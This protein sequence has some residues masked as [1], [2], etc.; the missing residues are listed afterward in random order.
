MKK[1]ALLLVAAALALSAASVGA[2]NLAGFDASKFP[3][4]VETEGVWRTVNTTSFKDGAQFAPS[5]AQLK[6]IMKLTSLSP[7]SVGMT[8]YLLVV[9]KDAAQQEDVIGKGKVNSG[10]V[11][12]LVFGDR[13]IATEQSLG[14]HTQQLDRGYYNAGIVSGYL[15]L[16]ALS[17]GFG[18]HF[19]MT[20]EYAAA[21]K[22]TMSLED[23]Y[24]KGKGYKYGIGYDPYK[25]GDANKQAEAYG[26]LKFI[27]G[28][29]IGTLDEKAQTKVTDHG[30]PENW[31]VAK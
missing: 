3:A 27:C 26:N 11:T 10:T 21:G 13:L 23:A 15:N 12:V 5:E 31:V 4:W 28:I 22:R 29:V 30:Y 17:Q 16:A 20:T 8:D 2:Q 1:F 25:R 14:K 18:T 6:T 9:L 19:Y 7:T 24:L